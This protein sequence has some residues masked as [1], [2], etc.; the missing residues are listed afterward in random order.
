[1]GI[2]RLYIVQV[3][4]GLIPLQV[5]SMSC[6]TGALVASRGILEVRQ[7]VDCNQ[8]PLFIRNMR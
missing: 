7:S 8:K 3:G 6:V 1:M 4:T 5:H 2:C